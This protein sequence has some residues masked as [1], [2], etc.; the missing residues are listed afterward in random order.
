MAKQSPV[1]EEKERVV[2]RTERFESHSR[3][4]VALHNGV[5]VVEITHCP[6]YKLSVNINLLEKW[7]TFIKDNHKMGPT[8]VCRRSEGPLVQ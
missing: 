4:N 7:R 3:L 6:S 1:G 8:K 2:R 5:A